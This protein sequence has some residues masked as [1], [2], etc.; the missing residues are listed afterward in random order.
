MT[1]LIQDVYSS[2]TQREQNSS[3][4]ELEG[5]GNGELLFNEYKFSAFQHE[6]SSRDE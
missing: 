3:G 6:K 5:Q 4:Q 1:P 2:Q